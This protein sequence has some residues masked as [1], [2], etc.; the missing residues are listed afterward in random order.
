M[1]KGILLAIL[2]LALVGII[3]FGAYSMNEENTAGNDDNVAVQEQEESEGQNAAENE[4]EF[5]QDGETVTYNGRDGQTA[6]EVLRSLT[7]VET[8][9]SDFGEFVVAING[10][11]ADTDKEFWAFYVNGEQANEGAGTYE[12]SDGDEL[13]WRLEESL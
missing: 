9:D 3:G 8:E 7:T 11:Q 5:S 10:V 2:A 4:I 13:Q 12:S 6:L 1:S